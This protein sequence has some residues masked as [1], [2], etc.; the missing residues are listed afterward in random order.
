[1]HTIQTTPG[2]FPFDVMRWYARI[3]ADTTDYTFPTL[4][5]SPCPNALLTMTS[6]DFKQNIPNNYKTLYAKEPKS[7]A[8]CSCFF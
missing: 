5:C 4:G 6:S 3:L 8:E 7:T 1:M 2:Y